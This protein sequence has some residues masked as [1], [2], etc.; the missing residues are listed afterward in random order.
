MK[1]F[2]SVIFSIV[3]LNV[4][5]AQDFKKVQTF[6]ML[7][8][9]ED[10]KVENDK[11]L[12]DAKNQSK[13]EAWYWKARLNAA[14]AKGEATKV[15]FPNAMKDAEGAIKK[16]VSLDP[17]FTVVKEKGAEGFFDMYSMNFN[18]G[19]TDFK[20]KI[21]PKAAE[22]FEAAVYYSDFIFQNKWANSKALFDTTSILYAAYSNQNTQKMDR[23]SMYY[24]RLAEAKC[25]GENFADIYKF[26]AD[27]GLRWDP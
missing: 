23:A 11:L 5:I 13:P 1:Y 9:I 20:D 22:D 24:N 17:A 15:I 14:L 19:L 21:W 3:L 27:Q 8:K 6:A 10:A 4:A 18:A 16:Y 7:G 25:T 26:L 12:A 2:F